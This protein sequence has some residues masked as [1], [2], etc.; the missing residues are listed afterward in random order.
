MIHGVW[1]WPVGEIADENGKVLTF[2]VVFVVLGAEISCKVLIFVT[3]H[4]FLTWLVGEVADKNGMEEVWGCDLHGC[5]FSCFKAQENFTSKVNLI[6]IRKLLL[7]IVICCIVHSG[8]G[9]KF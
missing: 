7:F 6:V 1:T 2:M 3:I 8:L 4:V 5:W 9:L